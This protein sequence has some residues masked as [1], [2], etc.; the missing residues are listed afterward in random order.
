MHPKIVSF[1]EGAKHTISRPLSELKELVAMPESYPSKIGWEEK[2]YK[3]ENGNLVYVEPVRPDCF[4]H[5]EVNPK[6]IIIGYK[7]EG[8]RCY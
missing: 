2:T 7:T 8:K 6:G 5:W 1:N 3:H 4:V